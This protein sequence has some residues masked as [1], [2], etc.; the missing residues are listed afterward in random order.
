MRLRDI[1]G[2]ITVWVLYGFIRRLWLVRNGYYGLLIILAV[3]IV[4]VVAAIWIIWRMLY[5]SGSF[6]KALM[7]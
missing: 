6:C 5:G 4:L 1:V 7:A 2:L 3:E